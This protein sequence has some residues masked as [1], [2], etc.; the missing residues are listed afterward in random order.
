M[1]TVPV[2]GEPFGRSVLKVDDGR[3]S[4][5]PEEKEVEIPV[6]CM[7]YGAD[8]GVTDGPLVE[9]ARSGKRT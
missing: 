3:G 7:W 1:P 6:T 2:H 4:Y 9:S 8:G 5:L